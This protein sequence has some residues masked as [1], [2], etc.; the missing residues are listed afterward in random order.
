ML[1][2][3]TQDCYIN[4]L[5]KAFQE[6]FV[7]WSFSTIGPVLYS[8][9][10]KTRDMTDNPYKYGCSATFDLW[11]RHLLISADQGSYRD[12]QNNKC[13]QYTV[14]RSPFAEPRDFNLCMRSFKPRWGWMTKM[15]TITS[16]SHVSRTYL[17]SSAC[18]GG[19]ILLDRIVDTS[20][21]WAS[22]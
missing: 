6:I 20:W 7:L 14:K 13:S 1:A 12:F 18:S 21:P 2:G 19:L 15:S 4:I 8:I 5:V 9:S 11:T 22:I 17:T 10:C 16:P 3:K